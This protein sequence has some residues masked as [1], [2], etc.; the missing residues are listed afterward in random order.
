MNIKNLVH[1]LLTLQVDIAVIVS[2]EV[3]D[4]DWRRLSPWQGIAPPIS[5]MIVPSPSTIITMGVFLQ[6]GVSF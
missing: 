1:F 3:W 4:L 5:T 2:I 6:K